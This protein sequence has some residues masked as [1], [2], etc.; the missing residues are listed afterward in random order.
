[1]MKEMIFIPLLPPS[2]QL[3]SIVVDVAPFPTMPTG[4]LGGP[5]RINST[6]SPLVAPGSALPQVDNQ[7]STLYTVHRNSNREIN[8]TA[9]VQFER[10]FAID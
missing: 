1:M 2:I 3:R 4:G 9:L 5:D 10:I 6:T 7:I 8:D